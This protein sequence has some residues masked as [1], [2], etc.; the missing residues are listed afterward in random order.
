MIISSH[1]DES[2]NE[3][4]K[5]LNYFNKQWI[6][7]NET[8]IIYIYHIE[9]QKS[10]S[11]NICLKINEFMLLLEEIK[12][13]WYRR[14]ILNF[15]EQFKIEFIPNSIN[16]QIAIHLKDERKAI[17]DFVYKYLFDSK[18]C[19]NN[20]LAAKNEKIYYMYCAQK[21]GL[22]IPDTIITDQTSLM[23]EFI[24]GKRGFF[25]SKPINENLAFEIDDVSINNSTARITLSMLEDIK[26]NYYLSLLQKY[27]EKY[28]EIRTFFLLD[29][30]YSMAIFSQ[31]NNKTK[32][33]YRNYDNDFP[34]RNVPYKL[35]DELENKIRNFMK[36]INLNCGSLDLILNKNNEYIFLEVNPV[37]QFGMVS[38]PCNYSLEK[39][40]A[41]KL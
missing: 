6:R 16:E 31:Q 14:G 32:L 9:F 39:R 40:I 15:R 12:A 19:I 20:I 36:E 35:P 38:Y 29:E 37:G 21:H 11:F 17:V 4:I 23:T 27:E 2:T 28:I 22:L 30:I 33:D 5:W 26:H 24:K 41:K 7:I 13:V 10:G 3:V 8:D 18:F 1:F 25:I 34:N